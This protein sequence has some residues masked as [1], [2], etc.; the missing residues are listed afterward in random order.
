VVGDTTDQASSD[1]E[2]GEVIE[3]D[4]PVGQRVDEGSTVNLVVSSGPDTVEV[5]N[6]A[7]YTYDRAKEALQGL[8]LKV[9]KQMQDSDEPRDQV[10][11][12]DPFSGSEV[13]AGSTVAL[14]VSKGQV[15]VPNLVGR[16]LDDAK[17][18]LDDLGLTYDNVIEDP[19]ATEEAGI[20]T[21]QSTSSGEKV[22]PGSNIQL[23]VS[24]KPDTPPE[25]TPPDTDGGDAD[26]GTDADVDG[27]DVFD[28]G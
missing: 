18:M 16:N 21:R 28:G 20:V 4:P 26:A 10:L 24:S 6:L 14:I 19:N 2:E 25:T 27:G 13:E 9:D 11:N 7:G 3:T 1:V 8:G 22:S 5:P 12:T 17:T 23:T 15:T